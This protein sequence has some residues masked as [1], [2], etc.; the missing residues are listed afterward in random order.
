VH[1]TGTS[2]LVAV[3]LSHGHLV[4]RWTYHTRVSLH[5]QLCGIECSTKF[6][7]LFTIRSVLFC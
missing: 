3:K 4:T 2:Q 6:L 5:S 7:L 1:V